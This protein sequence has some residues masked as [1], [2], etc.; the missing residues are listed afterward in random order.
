MQAEQT[1]AIVAICLMVAF[2]DQH[3]DERE[4]EHIRK[5]T[6]SLSADSGIDL[7]KIYQDVLLGRLGLDAAASALKTVELRRLAFE[8]AVGVC[9]ADGVHDER[10]TAFLDT[11]QSALA[12]DR[13]GADAFTVQADT[14]ASLPL[15]DTPPAPVTA[16][17]P[18]AASTIPR[19]S[20]MSDAELDKSIL[21]ASILNGALELLPQSLASMAIIPLQTRLV[22]RIGRSY[23]YE[24]D[25]GHIKDFLATAG[26]GLTSQ[27]IEQF[28]RKLVG[29]LLGKVL[30]KTGRTI[31]STATGSAFSFASTYALGQLARRYYAGGRSLSTDALKRS[32]SSLVNEA[33]GLQQHY[34]PQIEERARTLDVGN[35]M[36]ELRI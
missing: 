23:G 19:A 11:L 34:T 27:Y 28:G 36:S 16:V 30:G 9:D 13:A 22:Y 3:K 32:F 29:G 35:L 21:N 2:A 5:I 18:P 17:T 7:M 1:R 6:E 12:L 24:L 26:V 33:K 8:M 15:D 25:R 14:L 20:T 10:E 31:G 4:R